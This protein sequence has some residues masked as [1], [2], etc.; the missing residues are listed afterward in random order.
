[1]KNAYDT[2]M[3]IRATSS[4]NEKLAILQANTDDKDLKEFLRV[5]YEPSINFYVRKIDGSCGFQKAMD[6]KHG[7]F[8][9]WGVNIIAN[10]VHLLGNRQ[11]TGNEAKQWVCTLHS[12]LSPP[13]QEMIQ[14]LIDRDVRAGFSESTIN[15]VWPGLITDPPYMRCSLPKDA[16]LSSFDWDRGVFSQIKADGMFANLDIGR[17]GDVRLSSRNGSV[18]NVE[19]EGLTDLVV[20]AREAIK[21]S[22]QNV[23]IHGELLVINASTGAPLPRQESNGK[24]NALLKSGELDDGLEVIMECWD[25]IPADSAVA[26]GTCNTSYAM[27]FATLSTLLEGAESL[28]LIETR[29]VHNMEEAMAHYREALSRGLEGTI[30]KNPSMIWKDGTSKEQVKMKVEFEVDLRVTGYVEGKG[31]AAGTLGALECESACGQLKVQVGSGF[32]D[33]MRA[34]IWGRKDLNIITVKANSIMP[35]TSKATSSLFLPIFVEERL[36][37]H[38]ADTLERIQAQYESTVS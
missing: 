19:V 23:Q 15:K 34:D 5:C 25:V 28:R 21:K 36:D 35:P 38:E 12:L 2:I 20:A 9:A 4:K 14:M 37:K 22:D 11:I 13:E 33:A 31:K 24:L 8:W 3:K 29:R 32:T 16:K 27:R 10:M 30:I 1:M 7:D 18:F 26:K 6:M 17:Y